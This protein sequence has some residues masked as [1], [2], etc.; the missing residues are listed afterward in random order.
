MATTKGNEYSNFLRHLNI[1][2]KHKIQQQC[3]ESC[4]ENNRILLIDFTELYF[5]KNQNN[6][7]AI[8]KSFSNVC[9][10]CES[11]RSLNL[12][13]DYNPNFIFFQINGRAFLTD[14]PKNINIDNTEFKLLCVT[15]H[16]NNHFFGI[17][18]LNNN[19]YAV[20]DLDQSMT[21][22]PNPYS[23]RN[24]FYSKKATTCMYYKL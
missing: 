8:L 18:Y 16:Q 23:C 7:L 24:E 11:L 2:Q 9:Y 10:T 17:Y 3:S 19:F 4:S 22:L 20:D 5:Q 6:Q 15:V 21:Q 14:V 12:K 1:Y 13:F